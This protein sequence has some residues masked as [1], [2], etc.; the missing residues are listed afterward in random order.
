M[1]MKATAILAMAALMLSACK[2][3]DAPR[4]PRRTEAALQ[5]LK[6]GN[7]AKRVYLETGKYPA[8]EATLTPPEPCCGPGYNQ[9]PAVPALFAAPSVWAA[10]DFRIDKPSLFRYAYSASAD[11][12]SFVAK[13]VGDLDCDGVVITYDLAGSS[14]SGSPTLVLTEPAPNT[15]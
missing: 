1:T 5:L 12:Q 4:G 8:G 14:A 3:D 9:C 11:G 15:D 10:L 7:N 13:A 2:S 6:I